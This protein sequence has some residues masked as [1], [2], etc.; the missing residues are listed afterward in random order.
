MSKYKEELKKQ[1]VL[2]HKIKHYGPRVL[3]RKYG[4]SPEEKSKKEKR[5]NKLLPGKLR[6]NL[7]RQFPWGIVSVQLSMT[8][9]LFIFLWTVFTAPLF[10]DKKSFPFWNMKTPLG[11]MPKP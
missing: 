1:I 5:L 6:K 4:I 3:Q 11:L 2:E 7:I 9:L 8:T 10:R